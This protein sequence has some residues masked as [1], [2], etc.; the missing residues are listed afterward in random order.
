MQHS[1]ESYRGLGKPQQFEYLMETLS[2]TNRTPEYYVNWDKVYRNSNE[3]ELY[4]H[5]MNYLLGKEN[6]YNEALRLFEKQP[7]LLKAIPILLAIRDKK[8]PV[9]MLDDENQANYIH[10][11]FNKIKNEDIQS[12]VDFI[13]GAGLLS[14]ME[15]KLTNNL[16]DYV[17]GVEVGLDSN[18]RK[19][20]SGDTME[21]LVEQSVQDICN[22]NGYQYI[23]QATAA[24][25]KEEWNY[26]LPTDEAKRRHDFAVYC[27]NENKLSIIE[28]NYY[29]GGGSKLK[30]VAGEFVG[31]STFLLE[32]DPSI[33]FI[34]VTD[35]Q[36]WHTAR[37]PLYEAFLSL[38]NI[39]NL[40]MLNEGYLEEV[41]HR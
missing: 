34:W 38:D 32:R 27:P 8:F 26:E 19:N 21:F 40:H 39:F 28:V 13:Q 2:I 25:I 23:T 18:G 16:V 3:I 37:N 24:R 7:D 22:K 9:L 30:A 4:L 17:F 31:L 10:L 6:I 29:G 36:G 11:D 35:G 12:Y 20:R 5:T 15:N 1:L 41:L 14:F 33:K